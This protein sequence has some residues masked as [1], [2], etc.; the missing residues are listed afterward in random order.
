MLKLFIHFVFS[1]SHAIFDK[2]PA[3]RIAFI[4]PA[5]WLASFQAFQL[6]S[7]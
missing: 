6:Y 1:I 4:P 2:L 5:F 7:L 3:A